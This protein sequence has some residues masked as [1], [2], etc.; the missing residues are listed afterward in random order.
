MIPNRKI[1]VNLSGVRWVAENAAIG[2]AK[3]I[4]VRTAAGMASTISGDAAAPNRTMTS[5]KIA[6]IERQPERDP[7]EVAEGDVARRDRRRVH[8]VEDPVPAQPAHDRERRLERRRLHRRR[9]QQARGQELRG[10]GTPPSDVASP[11]VDVRRRARGP[12]R[13]GTGPGSGTSGRSTPGTSAGT[14]A[15]GARRPGRAGRARTARRRSPPSGAYSISDR[16]VSRRKTSSSDDRRT[17]TVSGCRPRCVDGDRGRLAVVGVEQDPVGQ[18]LDP[19]GDARRAGR[20]ASPGRRARSAARS[21]SLRRVPLDQL[22]AGEPSA[23]IFALS[24]T[25]SRSHSC[26]ASSM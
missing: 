25:T 1:A 16:P 13:S 20:R 10:S 5:V 18:A 14:A 26:S 24:M 15:S 17:S 4:P 12:S 22:R 23:T 19:L 6:A 8:R 9:R 7:G 11:T 3:A 2:A 21:T